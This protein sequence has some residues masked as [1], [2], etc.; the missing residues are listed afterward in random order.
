VLVFSLTLRDSSV[1]W[2]YHH[3]YFFLRCIQ[4]LSMYS[5]TAF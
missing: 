2:R 4:C 5:T 3:Y 1:F